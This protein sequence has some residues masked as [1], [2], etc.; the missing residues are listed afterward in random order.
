MSDNLS[1]GLE[2]KTVL[3]TGATGAIGGAVAKGFSEAG[4]K[5][6]V[7]D[8]DQAQCDEFAQ[9]L[10]PRHAGFGVDLTDTARLSSL[11][12]KIDS[13]LGKIDVLVNIAGVIKRADDLFQV[14]E[15]DFDFQMD[16]NV[17]VPFFLS[18][19]VAKLMVDDGRSGVI[20]NYSSQG[21]MSGGF[22]GS[23]VYNAGKGA[24]TTMTRGLARSWADHG[25]RVNSVAPGLVETPM[26]GLDRMSEG[27]IENMVGG[28]PLKRLAQP[29][30]HTGATLFLASDH[31]AYMT[32]ATINVSGGFLMY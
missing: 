10:G 19:A 24:I 12:E 9:E 23:V 17:K 1:F 25:I 30:D 11:V 8:I 27:Q 14:S 18:Q 29:G 28:I 32:G 3:L 20:I 21:W 31:A 13:T 7:V 5:V 6:A 2:G 16:I 22:G 15:S 26:L 4:S